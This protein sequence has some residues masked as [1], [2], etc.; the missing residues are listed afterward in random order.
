ML[1][2][3]IPRL[4]AIRLPDKEAVVCESGKR[5]SWSQ[6]ENSVEA[7]ACMLAA[8]GV[9]KGEVVSSLS[10]N[11]LEII[12]IYLA[13]NRLGAIFAP[14]NYRFANPE[15]LQV[16][17]DGRPKVFIVQE[18][19][20]VTSDWLKESGQLDCVER[21]LTF[22]GTNSS[23]AQ[24]VAAAPARDYFPEIHDEDLSWIC[25]T[26][27]TTGRSKGVQLTHRAMTATSIDFIVC[28][29]IQ[30]DDVYYVAGALF[31]I[32]LVVP[33]AFWMIGAKAV[34][35]NFEPARSLRAISEEKVTHTIATGTIFKMLTEEMEA[36]PLPTVLKLIWV[37]GAPVSP[38]LVKRSRKQFGCDIGNIYGQTEVS[39]LA[40][41]LRQKDYD[42]GFAAPEGSR[43]ARRLQSVGRSAPMCSVRIVDD[44]MNTLPPETIGEIAVYGPTTMSGYANMPEATSD[45]LR[46]G[47]VRSGDLG[48]MDDDGYLYL[49][50]RKKDMI[51]TGG[52]NVYSSEV[53]LVL[54]R[55]PEVGE[56]V[57]I[58]LPDPHWGEA[59][60][61]L[62]IPRPG[63]RP[64]A[65]ELR[66]FC[67]DHLA[68]Y[69]VPKRI[70]FFEAFPRLPNGKIAKGQ[71]RD[72]YW[73]DRD[74]R[75]AGI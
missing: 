5:Q 33:F 74:T 61:A 62:V 25:Y 17:L 53:E 49:V 1:M 40:T 44:D 37:G 8:A 21:W 57:V 26:G 29:G 16:L 70:D 45:T 9:R 56:A 6:L 38:E 27:G 13:A 43:E 2:H 12:H 73:Q 22:G 10:K 11:C 52:E 46:D 31:H 66:K 48:T 34:I 15:I 75:I 24:A 47:W 19:Y 30:P 14:V 55:H 4:Q 72:Q 39:L 50:D 71:L 36:R 63:A 32:A 23:Y 67:R 3:D 28:G 65:E 54:C 64:E 58:G 51:I 35:G 18:E 60:L 7:I 42:L 41:V 69:K 20:Q 59:V 68:G